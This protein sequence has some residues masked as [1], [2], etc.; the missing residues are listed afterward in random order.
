VPSALAAL[1]ELL[2]LPTFDFSIPGRT[3]EGP[4]PPIEAR[5]AGAPKGRGLLR[6]AVAPPQHG[7]LRPMPPEKFFQISV[8]KSRILM[9]FAS[10]ITESV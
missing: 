5:S 1:D 4:K 9:H 10:N 6:G 7:G 2:G 3:I 8:A